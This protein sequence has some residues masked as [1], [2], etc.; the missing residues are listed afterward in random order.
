MAV[1]QL[2][3]F[4]KVALKWTN[5]GLGTTGQ[6]LAT[7][8]T[9]SSTNLK[10]VNPTSGTVTSVATGTGLTGGPITGSGT[11]SLANTAVTAGSYTQANITVNPQGQVTSASSSLGSTYTTGTATLVAST[12]TVTDA[13]IT[14][15]SKVVV[16]YIN[17]LVD[18][19]V[20]G[21]LYCVRSAGSM[22]INS[23]HASDVNN[24]C[25][26]IYY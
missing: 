12:A 5:F 15:T 20:M 6:V 16:S 11:V 24:V 8:T 4:D 23:N 22:T 7:D 18:A 10:W 1:N 2:Q 14:A 3:V 9:V 19:S 13:N 26:V 25:Y 17:P 21:N